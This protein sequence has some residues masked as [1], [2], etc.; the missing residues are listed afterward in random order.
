MRHLSDMRGLSFSFE[1]QNKWRLGF[2]KL[3]EQEKQDDQR[4]T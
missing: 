1:E 2:E 4:R 3:L